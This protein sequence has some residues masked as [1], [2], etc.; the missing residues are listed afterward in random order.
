MALNFLNNGYFAGKVGIGTESPNAKL[1]VNSAITFSTIDTFGQLVVKAASG[2][3]GDMLNIGVDTANSVT[4]IQA[5]DRGVGT[6]PLSLQRY[7]GYVGIGTISPTTPL[8]I[9]SSGSDEFIKIENTATYTGLWMNDSGTNNG[10]LVLSGY[11]DAVSLGDFAIRE[12]GVQTSLTIKQTTGNVGIGT[13]SP[14]AG[15][16][17]AKGG[18]TIPV[19]GSSTAS[20][21]FGN[22][23]S[24][25][26]YGVAIGA[27]SSGVGYISSQRTDGTA[28]TYSLAIQPNGGRVGIGTTSPTANLHVY[29]ST[30]SSTIEVGRGAGRSSIKASADA[31]GGY[32]ALDSSGNALILNHYSS[33]NVWLVTGGGNVGVGNTGPSQKLH[34]TG[35]LRVTGAYYDSNNSPG[36]ANQVLVSTASGTDW[37]DG[38]AIPGVPAGS[39]TLNTIPLW[40][41]DGDTLGNSVMTQSGANIGIGTTSYTNSSGYS[42]LNIN[43]TSGGQIAFQTAGASKH[44][45]WGTATDFNIYNGQAGPLILYTSATERMRIT[46]AGNATFAGNVTAPTFIG[47]VTGNLTGIVTATSSLADG[48]TGTTQGDSDDS[49][50]IATTAFV[51]NLIETIPAGLVFQGTWNAATNTP[52]LASGVGTTGN[53]YIVSVDG[54]TNLD[55]ITDWKVGDWAVFVEVGATDAWQKI[56]NSSVLDGF[57]TGGTV[58]GWA[59]SGTS[60]TLTNSPITFSSNDVTF[61]G[62]VGVGTSPS[63][64]YPGTHNLVVGDGGGEHAVT[65]YS[66]ATSTGYLL[67]ADGSSGSSRYAGQVRYDHNTDSMEFSVNNS[68]TAKLT[69]NSLGNATFAGDV[70]LT[71]GQLVVTHDTNNTAKIIQAATSMSNGNYTLEVDSSSHSSNMT[72]AGAMAVDVYDGRAFTIDGK[73]DIGIG[74][75]AP[76]TLLHVKGG[77]DDNESLLYI[78]NTHSTGGTQY[79]SAMFTNTYGNHSFGTVAEFRIQN[80]S[81][82]DRPSILFTNGI[83]TN[84]WSVGQGVYSANDNFAIGF[85]TGHPGVVSA[86]ADPKLVILTSGNVGIGTNSP[87]EKLEVSGKV[88]IESQGVDWNETTPGLTRGAL[89][90]DPVGNGAA[91]TGNAITFGASDHSNGGV[92]DAGIY[93]RSDGTYGSKMYFATTDSYAVGS[94]TAMMIDNAGNVGIG[95]TS[96]STKIDVYQSTVGIGVADFRHVNGNRILINPSY[97]YY[98]AYNHIFRG[99]NGTDTHMTIDLNGNVGIGT[100][101]PTAAKLVVS[102]NTA[103]QLLIKCPSGGSSIAQILLEENSGGTQNASITFDQA[104]NNTLTIATGY[105]SPTDENKIA[106]TPGTTTAMTLRGGDDS[107]NT[108]GAIQ[109]NGYVGTRQTGTPTYLLGTDASGNVVK[110]LTTPSPITSQAA[111]LYDLIPNGAFTTTY[112]FTSTAGT[113]AEVMSGDDVITAAGTYSVQ[114]YVSDYAVGGTQ[115]REYYSGVMSWNYPDNTNDT[116]IGAISEIVLHRAGHAA[117]QGITYLRTRETGAAGNNELKLEIM[118]NRTYTGASNVVFKF[119]RLI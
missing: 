96:P 91:N 59:G 110:T 106:L 5:N 100:T 67:F 14:A 42:T 43:G 75:N 19:A 17:V 90:F 39:G 117:N 53:F 20:A 112:A 58:T 34:I 52:T 93:T 66:G 83:T 107:T 115:Y 30:N 49:E 33:D 47:N 97:N 12:Y 105:V 76:A 71:N 60:N 109:F 56:D 46:S 89:H 41:P 50:L 35:N 45:I 51:Q 104:A 13:T 103:P 80:G 119:V 40:T 38:S 9:E 79:P 84:N 108:A 88:Y 78:E 57:G 102:S 28:T 85:R 36:T 94:K 77:A 87:N 68:S 10:W 15:L 86:W 118:C 114:M 82:A 116:G 18:T 65:V 92:A 72:S 62:N 101:S 16:Q 4:F 32:L 69:I 44:F 26:N 48:V 21:V 55:G 3:T 22:S 1:E 8:S 99:L 11:T 95:D 37:V 25:D 64:F 98:D 2:S 81:G 54:S 6:I 74:T 70:S 7:G 113:Y 61:S 27:N 29:T 73:G 31:D 24:D 111:S 63:S 23:T